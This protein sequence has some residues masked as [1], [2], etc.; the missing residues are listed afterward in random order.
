MQSMISIFLGYFFQLGIITPSHCLLWPASFCKLINIL[1]K[2][3]FEAKAKVPRGRGAWYVVWLLSRK[4][5][6]RWSD[7]GE[8]D[9]LEHVGYD[10]DRVHATIY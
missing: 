6:F 9:I 10:M 5:P 8:I 4:Q 1:L 2:V 7:N 3:V